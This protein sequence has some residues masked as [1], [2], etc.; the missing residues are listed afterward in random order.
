VPNYQVSINNEQE[1]ALT[2]ELAQQTP[3]LTIAE[4]LQNWVTRQAKEI[5]NRTRE[6]DES[7]WIVAIRNTTP[8]QRQEIKTILG[9]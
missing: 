1:A 7:T 8:A 3:V 4:T 6:H 2:R 9:L 5:V